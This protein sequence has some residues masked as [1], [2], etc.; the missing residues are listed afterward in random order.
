MEKEKNS[1]ESRVAHNIK[2]WRFRRDWTPEE[3]SMYSGV[4]RSTIRRIEKEAPNTTIS[5]VQALAKALK[6]DPI[7]LFEKY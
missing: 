5:N 7:R 4:S 3:L 2:E 6:I 1:I